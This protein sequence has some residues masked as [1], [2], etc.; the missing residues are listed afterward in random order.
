MGPDD[1]VQRVLKTGV[2]SAGDYGIA[3]AVGRR[4]G[5]VFA[6]GRGIAGGSWPGDEG[7]IHTL[8][9]QADTSKLAVVLLEMKIEEKYGLPDQIQWQPT[10]GA[11][12]EVGQRVWVLQ[13]GD[14][15]DEKVQGVIASLCEDFLGTG[16]FIVQLD[17]GARVVTCAP[18]RRG[19]QWD[20]AT[21]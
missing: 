3:I 14:N 9:V 4:S 15:A 11:A 16:G 1:G 5:K 12:I 20:F 8:Q 6:E 19:T 13:R 18:D 17:G 10:V 21:E 2:A 7:I